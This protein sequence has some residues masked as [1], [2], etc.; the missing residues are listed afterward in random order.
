MRRLP[1]AVRQEVAKQLKDMQQAGVLQPSSS[2]WA[3]PVVMVRKNDGTHRFCVD[4]RTLNAV[5]KPD[6]Y[7]LP[8]IDDL[9]DQLGE[10]RYFSTLNLASGYWQICV[11]P[12]S[13]EK[14]SLSLR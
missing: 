12:D 7:P 10:S 14:D 8:R 2:P 4:Y 1:F 11:H 5:T 6:L 9:L 3:S 13:V